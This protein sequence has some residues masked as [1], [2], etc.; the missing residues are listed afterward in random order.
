[1]QSIV[2][3]KPTTIGVIE[4]VAGLDINDVALRCVPEGVPYLIVDTS[5]LPTDGKYRDAWDAD[6]SEPDGVGIGP[7]NYFIQKARGNL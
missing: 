6:F 5:E 7:E 4:P 2:Y 1:M 3:K